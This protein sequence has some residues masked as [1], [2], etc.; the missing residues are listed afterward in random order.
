[1]VQEYDDSSYYKTIAIMGLTPK[2]E[3]D[4]KEYVKN[5]FPEYVKVKIV[6]ISNMSPEE[7]K[8]ERDTC[9]ILVNDEL[10]DS[11]K[12]P[13]L[14]SFV[15]NVRTEEQINNIIIVPITEKILSTRQ[16][17]EMANSVRNLY[18]NLSPR[19]K[20]KVAVSPENIEELHSIESFFDM[21]I[22]SPIIQDVAMARDMDTDQ[23]REIF[24][25]E[26]F[27][28]LE[29]EHPYTRGHLERVGI[30]VDAIA[31]MMGEEYSHTVFRQK[32]Y[33][34]MAKFLAQI[35]DIGKLAISYDILNSPDKFGANSK[36][37]AHLDTHSSSG[38]AMVT[39]S[40]LAGKYRYDPEKG[41]SEHHT[42]DTKNPFAN[43]IKIADC[44]DAMASDR[45]Y[46]EPKN[47]IDCLRDLLYNSDARFGGVNPNTN[48]KPQFNRRL[49]RAFIKVLISQA[50]SIGYDVK[51]MLKAVKGE[52]YDARIRFYSAK[53]DD[54]LIK[55]CEGIEVNKDANIGDYCALGFKLGPKGNIIFENAE[56]YKADVGISPEERM[57]RLKN[58]TYYDMIYEFYRKYLPTDRKQPLLD[59]Q[60]K[61]KN[62]GGNFSI[63]PK[64]IISVM[65]DEEKKRYVD[66][67]DQLVLDRLQAK[68][69]FGRKIVEIGYAGNDKKLKYVLDASEDKS[70]SL[71]ITKA[72]SKLI[73]DINREDKSEI[74]DFSQIYSELDFLFNDA[75]ETTL[76]K[77]PQGLLDFVKRSKDPNHN[78]SLS[79]YIS[80]SSQMLHRNT[81]NLASSIYLRYICDKNSEKRRLANVYKGNYEKEMAKLKREMNAPNSYSTRNTDER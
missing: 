5:N 36:E 17:M 48:E 58:E 54:E 62:E 9:C 33:R 43:I 23:R 15:R 47:F 11:E 68:E 2:I 37:R 67:R 63:N 41:I 34:D 29:K 56:R 71:S 27:E 80:L 18:I 76:E 6:D 20:E 55:L 19:E 24:V 69:N 51:E 3:A 12:R 66:E 16:A 7:A 46:N 28:A 60:E 4:L 79:P 30:F 50:A 22:K 40:L 53:L 65:T 14:E 10:I 73:S 77:I 52:C 25:K 64:T 26:V 45:G 72:A 74:S 39:S 44:F 81:Y 59:A 32:E 13:I 57:N 42:R 1:M 75:S 21:S 49:T 38:I 35:H 70:N 8:R 61:A 78:V 31:K